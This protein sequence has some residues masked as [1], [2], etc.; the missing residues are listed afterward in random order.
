MRGIRDIDLVRLEGMGLQEVIDFVEDC[1]YSTEALDNESIFQL[2][3]DILDGHADGRP[4]LME[5]LDFSDD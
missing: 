5:E 3:E 2:A 4:P 1:G